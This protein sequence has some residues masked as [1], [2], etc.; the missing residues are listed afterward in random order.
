MFELSSELKLS[1]KDY[2]R[3]LQRKYQDESN[4]TEIELKKLITEY[5]GE[6]EQVTSL[7]DK[8]LKE[9]TSKGAIIGVDGSVNTTGK[10]YPHYI[11]LLQALA[12]SSTNQ[13][14]VIQHEIFSPLVEED[15]EKIFKK[16]SKEESENA[17]EAAGKIRT[18]LL[19]A[20]EV[21]VAYES[22]KRFN[23]QLI[24]MD[25]SL[26]R[27]CYQAEDL[28]QELVDLAIAENVLLVGVIEEIA[29]H[30]LSKELKSK[31]QLPIQ[32]KDMYDRELL[33]GLL[34]QG[35]VLKFNS[36]IDFKPGLET[37]FLRPSRDPGVV[38]IDM[39]DQQ[40]DRLDFMVQLVHSLTPEGG[41]GIPLWLDIVDNEVRITDQMMEFL[42]ENYLDPALKQ[43]LFHSKRADRIF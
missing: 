31:S 16:M 32:M 41:R 3:K 13:G 18:S 24:M 17:Q 1:L 36:E 34:E 26:I 29:T 5:L 12:K 38:G 15:K 4:L 35:Q 42:L 30:Q 10:V 9:W 37:V 8:E 23:P 22:I 7:K 21:K 14:E 28:W 19:A 27:Y 2:N 43:R 40:K 11:T 39:L 6:F 25:G 20:L 33:F